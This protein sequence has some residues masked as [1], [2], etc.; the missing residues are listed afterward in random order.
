MDMTLERA[1]G[2]VGLTVH[3][4]DERQVD[5]PIETADMPRLHDVRLI[6]RDGDETQL[7]EM[8]VDYYCV[9][10]VS[11]VMETAAQIEANRLT[12]RCPA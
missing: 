10:V 1:G 2:C 4:R 7:R 6:M 8:S 11:S 9:L 12:L 5:A 3:H